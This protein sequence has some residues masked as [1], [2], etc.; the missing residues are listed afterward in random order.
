MNI[1]AGGC[2]RRQATKRFSTQTIRGRKLSALPQTISIPSPLLCFS[3]KFSLSTS[4]LIRWIQMSPRTPNSF[5]LLDGFYVVTWYKCVLHFSHRSYKMTLAGRKMQKKH[6]ELFAQPC[7]SLTVHRS[8]VGGKKLSSKACSG[9]RVRHVVHQTAVMTKAVQLNTSLKLSAVHLH[10]RTCAHVGSHTL[11][12]WSK[13][14][15]PMQTGTIP[16]HPS[17]WTGGKQHKHWPWQKA[18][19]AFLLK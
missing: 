2:C 5:L 9:Y 13:L 17:G 19:W 15:T 6:C 4:Y 11:Q 18:N 14:Q 7:V 16:Q 3:S 8:D 12:R 10:W 1:L